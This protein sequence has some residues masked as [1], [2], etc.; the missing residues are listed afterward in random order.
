MSTHNISFGDEIQRIFVCIALL[1]RAMYMFD[2]EINPQCANH[3]CSRQ[4]FSF[5]HF[6]EN[7]A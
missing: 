3:N 6:S 4:H 2:G 1:S 7:K 5:V